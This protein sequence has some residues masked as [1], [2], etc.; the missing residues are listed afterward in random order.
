MIFPMDRVGLMPG[1]NYMVFKLVFEIP[2]GRILGAQAIGTGECDKRVDVIAA[3]ITMGGRLEDL[4][5]LEL[6]YAPPFST[7]KDVVNLAALVALNVLN[8]RIK[9]VHVDKVRELVEQGAYI[10][11]VRKRV[12]LRGHIIFLLMSSETDWM[13]FQ[14]IFRYTC[15][16]DPASAP[17]TQ[18]AL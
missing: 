9:Q 1:A 16:A 17:I 10:I 2:T 5:E 4:K 11:D 14:G 7:A 6:C 18:P 3:M 12:T 15:T 8:G 13:K